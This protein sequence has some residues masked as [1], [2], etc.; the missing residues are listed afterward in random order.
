MVRRAVHRPA[1]AGIGA[2]DAGDHVFRDA[3][4][5]VDRTP[6][7]GRGTDRRQPCLSWIA[8]AG[9]LGWLSRTAARGRWQRTFMDATNPVDL[10]PDR[11]AGVIGELANMI[12]GACSSELESDAN[13]D[14]GRAGSDA[15]S[16]RRSQVPILPR[17][18]V[19]LPS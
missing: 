11:I 18:A 6:K 3:R 5:G 12:C 14:L 1:A 15:W 19:R 7:T 10:R 8:A 16:A 4:R 13:F 2:E 9:G 17:V